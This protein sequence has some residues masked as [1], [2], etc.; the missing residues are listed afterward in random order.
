MAVKAKGIID[1][2]EYASYNYHKFER[3]N[4]FNQADWTLFMRAAAIH[5]YEEVFLWIG[6]YPRC[7]RGSVCEVNSGRVFQN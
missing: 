4:I 6:P 2:I 5:K 1:R 7:S 3:K